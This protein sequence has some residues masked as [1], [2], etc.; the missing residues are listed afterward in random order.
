MIL[1][2]TERTILDLFRQLLESPP[3]EI[4]RGFRAS[5]L[6]QFV[7]LPTEFGNHFVRAAGSAEAAAE[8]SRSQTLVLQALF[9]LAELI[10]SERE[11][12]LEQAA[13]RVIEQPQPTGII[14][15]GRL[16]IELDRNLVLVPFATSQFDGASVVQFERRDARDLSRPTEVVRRARRKVEQQAPQEFQQSR[17]ACFVRTI[18]NLQSVIRELRGRTH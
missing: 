12:R 3:R 7:R 10:E 4:D 8:Q 18:D 15:I 14:E 13:I 16:S 6:E 5:L 11:D 17:L 1:L 9:A 2:G